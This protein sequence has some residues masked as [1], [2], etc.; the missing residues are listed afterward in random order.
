MVLKEAS[1]VLTRSPGFSAVVVLILGVSLGLGT[2]IFSIVYGV[3]MRP[4]PYADPASLVSVHLTAE[5]LNTRTQIP[6]RVSVPELRD[7]AERLNTFAAVGAWTPWRHGIDTGSGLESTTTAYISNQFFTLLGGAAVA[8][9]RA[10]RGRGEPEIVISDRLWKSRLGGR[11]DVVGMRMR[12]NSQLFTVVGVAR[13]DFYFPTEETDAWLPVEHLEGADNRNV[14][15]LQVLGRLAAGASLA[16]AQGDVSRLTGSLYAEVPIRGT[17][18]VSSTTRELQDELT[19]PVRPALLALFGAVLLILIAA[20]ASAANFFLARLVSRTHEIATRVALGESRRHVLLTLATESGLL[21]AAGWLTGLFLAWVVIAFV[22]THPTP[23]PRIGGI[24]IGWPVMMFGLAAA[25]AIWCTVAAVLAVRVSRFMPWPSLQATAA[26]VTDA[27]G[28]KWVTSTLLVVELAICFVLLVGVTVLGRSFTRLLRTDIGVATGQV[29]TSELILATDRRLPPGRQIAMIETLHEQLAQLPS[30]DAVG[31]GLSLPPTER[32]GSYEVPVGQSIVQM[33]LVSVSN[34]YFEALGIPLIKGRDFAESDAAGSPE[35]MIL[36]ASA[37]RMIFGDR[38]P[39]GRALPGFAISVVGV[40]GDVKYSGL[41]AEAGATVYRPYRQFPVPSVFLVV[42]SARDASAIARDVR[43]IVQSV[44][45][46]VV[47]TRF[48][49]LEDRVS[50]VVALPRLQTVTIGVLALLALLV[51]GIGSYALADHSVTRRT[52]EFAIRIAVGATPVKLLL[53]VLGESALLSAAGTLAGV[54]IVYTL[55]QSASGL[56]GNM[57][58]MDMS[59][60]TPVALFLLVWMVIAHFIPARR[61]A[62]FEPWPSL[63]S[64][65]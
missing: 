16:Q 43:R 1:R 35:V 61:A 11:A 15:Q 38:D 36:S 52:R 56:F 46:Q 65:R 64:E 4:L 23:L 54:G 63:S 44:D 55:R 40:V 26:S 10:A 47:V 32:R 60:W 62:R 20:A 14:R 25:A 17:G 59:T 39:V 24:E 33:G 8:Q 50:N 27:R 19:A 9:G 7:W 42:K 5:Q 41:D 48:E 30:T 34:G 28:A 18:P 37:A 2:G 53:A 31:F 45:N 49:P 58:G 22:R 6:I 29:T 3:L 57:L 21:A 12:V 51:V 13:P